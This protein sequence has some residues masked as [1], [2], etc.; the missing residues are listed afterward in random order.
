[1][2]F[3]CDQ[4]GI[5]CKHID[6]IPQLK[7]FD[8]GNGRC[9]NLTNNNLCAIYEDRPEICNIAKMYELEYCRQMT[10]DEY[11]YLNFEGCKELKRIYSEYNNYL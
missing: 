7:Q 10:E 11:L 9:I 5:C 2:I 6:Q 4:C 8:Q 3:V 1:M